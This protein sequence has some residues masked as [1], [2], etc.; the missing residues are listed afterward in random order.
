MLSQQVLAHETFK[1]VE[2]VPDV[3]YDHRPR[4]GC[5]ICSDRGVRVQAVNVADSF[6]C[7]AAVN[8]DHYW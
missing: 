5:C 3:D 2:A 6:L 7:T 1:P 8:F 4:E